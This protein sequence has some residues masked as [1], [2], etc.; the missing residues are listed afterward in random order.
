MI[1]HQVWRPFILALA[2]S[3][4]AGLVAQPN[5]LYILADDLGYGDLGCY[6]QEKTK[7]PNLDR[8]AR[9]GMRFTQH[10][11]GCT[12]CSPSRCAL[13][14]GRHTG[15][16]TVR[17]NSDVLMRTGEP[18]LASVLKGAGYRTA[19]IGKWG[20]GHP[21]P[22][23]D[24][25]RFGF[26][27]F[28][29]YLSMWHAHNAYPEF[30]WRNSE[31][32]LLRNVVRHPSTHYKE[33][34]AE[35][36]G[37]AEKRVD[38]AS[39]LCT[40]ESHQFIGETSQ[41][42]F[43]FLC[44]TVPHANNEAIELGAPHGIEVPDLGP[45]EKEK[46]PEAEKA[47]AALISRMDADI[48]ALLA[49]LKQRKV[50]GNTLVIFASDNGPHREGGVNPDF[51]ASSGPLRGAKRDLYEGGIRVPMIALWPGHIR[52]GRVSSHVSAFWDILPTFA[53]VAGVPSP[54]NLDGISLLPELLGRL[55]PKHEYLYWEFHEGASKQ[56]VRMADWKAVRLAPSASIELY[57]LK[58]DP[59]EQNDVAALHPDVITRMREILER[60]R[61]DEATWPLLET[62]DKMPF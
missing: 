55:Q 42:F 30:L 52:A 44:Y 34:Q 36:T 3:S 23:G 51:L 35:L 33:N 41:P 13:M 54:K 26:D 56:A 39:D 37:Y 60:S 19:C 49:A 46:W 8:L 25:Q 57:D 32:V 16:C 40:Q 58:S 5:V 14:T 9:E 15:H 20:I 61:N 22:P 28:Y 17:A 24:P 62:A 47:K 27:A 38:L 48:G 7:T 18:T 53:E 29:G 11:A 2:L 6:G 12:V 59:G 50:D 45:Y 1:L 31:K 4:S 10:Y 43:L 21:P